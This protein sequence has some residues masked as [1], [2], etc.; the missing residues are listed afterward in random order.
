M[1]V[2]G[3]LTCSTEP[4]ACAVDSDLLGLRKGGSRHCEN[5]S[6]EGGG[7][8][9]LTKPLQLRW[10]PALAVSHPG[11]ASLGAQDTAA[12]GHLG[13]CASGQGGLWEPEVEGQTDAPYPV[14]A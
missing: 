11:L 13:E 12:N 8:S 4:R 3:T 5:P 6:A 7:D 1:E 14:Q 9:R 10:K 2:V